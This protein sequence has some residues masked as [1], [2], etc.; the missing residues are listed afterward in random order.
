MYSTPN[1]MSA[2][3]INKNHLFLL[4]SY[5][6]F[7]INTNMRCYFMFPEI[8]MRTK[9]TYFQLR[10]ILCNVHEHLFSYYLGS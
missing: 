7:Q 10:D 1:V 6:P 3:L 9:I 2:F 4:Y 8:P 5:Y